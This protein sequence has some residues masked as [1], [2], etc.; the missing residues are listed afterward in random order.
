MGLAA[1][2]ETFYAN[3]GGTKTVY[4]YDW[5]N[6]DNWKVKDGDGNLV[7][8]PTAPQQG[9]T[10]IFDKTV[11]GMMSLY[12][13]SAVAPGLQRV[14]F[15]ANNTIHQGYV[16]ILAGGDGLI[17]NFVGAMTWYAGIHIAGTGEASVDVPAGATFNGQKG[18]RT[19]SKTTDVTFVKKG[20]GNFVTAYEGGNIYNPTCA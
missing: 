4:A 13:D 8:A 14:Q 17:M 2:A 15:N 1:R 20:A 5:F 6:K 11:S 3:G 12:P 18:I 9:D 7:D 16:S 19:A 10:A